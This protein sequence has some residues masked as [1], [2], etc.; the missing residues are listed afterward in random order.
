[1]RKPSRYQMES[2]IHGAPL[3]YLRF[4]DILIQLGLLTEMSY[5]NSESQERQVLYD[6]WKILRGE[7]QEMVYVENLRV[8]IQVI[9]RLI[10]PKRVVD[11]QKL[12][13]RVADLERNEHQGT[14][15]LAD[16]IYNNDIGF[17]NDR[18][19]ICIRTTEVQKIQSHFNI[20]YLNRLQFYKK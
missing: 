2:P 19:Q 16:D 3:N 8:L 13:S 17:K 11:V 18:G 12:N 14:T 9:L 20:Y 6:L 1:M 7:E 5:A 15:T 4:K 10:D